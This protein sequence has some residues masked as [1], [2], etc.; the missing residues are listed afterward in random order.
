MFN[1]FETYAM[2]LS[3]VAMAVA[4]FLL[5]AETSTDQLA[6]I[7]PVNQTGSVFVADSANTRAALADAIIEAADN[8]GNINRL[9]IND[10]RPGEGKQAAVGDT[11][12]LHYIGTLRNGQQ[13]DNSYERGE[14]FSFTLGEGRVIAGWEEGLLGMQ[15]GGHRILV[16]PAELGYGK[17]GFGPI[18]KN[19]TLVFAVELLSINE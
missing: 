19:A 15:A 10:V 12:T 14:S 8:S 7:T 3:I 18:P 16:I 11:L 1:K 13:F 9:I 6:D 2:G 17:A 5:R 4:L